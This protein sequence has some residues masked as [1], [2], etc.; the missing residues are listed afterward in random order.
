MVMVDLRKVKFEADPLT[1]FKIQQTMAKNPEYARILNTNITTQIYEYLK[2]KN[3][4]KENVNF[5]FKGECN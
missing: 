5:A 3:K 2:Y 1:E 4:M